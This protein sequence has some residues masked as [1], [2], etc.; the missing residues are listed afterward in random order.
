MPTADILLK[1][2]D[3]PVVDKFV[4]FVGTLDNEKKSSM[5]YFIEG[6]NFVKAIYEAELAHVQLSMEHD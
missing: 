3:K 6:A 2:E 1:T 5:L 4:A